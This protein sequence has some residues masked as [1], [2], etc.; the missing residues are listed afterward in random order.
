MAVADKQ[1]DSIRKDYLKIYGPAVLMTLLA[2]VLAYQFVDPA[3]PDRI[4]MVTGREG[5]AYYSFA[6]RYAEILAR[7]RVT[8]EIRSTAGSV[9]NIKLLESQTEEVDLAFVQSGLEASAESGELVSLGSVYFEPLWVFVRREVEATSLADLHH[10]RMAVGEEGSGTRAVA[11]LLLKD[12]GIDVTRS[13]VLPMASGV[14]ARALVAGAIDA[15]F[16]VASPESAVVRELIRND[17]VV[18]MNFERAEAYTRRHRFLSAVDLPKGVLDFRLNIPPDDVTLLA[19]TANL[20]VSEDFHPAL[21]DL[22]LQV[23]EE[24]H[25]QGSLFADAGDFPCAEFL[26]FPLSKEAERF[27]RYGRPFLQKYMPFWAASLVDRLKVMLVP[28]IAMMF[29]LFKIMPPTYRWRVRSRI[30]RWYKQ[31]DAVALAAIDGT[32]EAESRELLT[33]LD[34][35]E[36]EVTKMSIPLSYHEEWYNLRLHINHVREQLQR[37][38]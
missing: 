7:Q 5:G 16:F 30:Y 22:V 13:S 21:V 1:T 33:K 23:A 26:A 29:P 15:A 8:L 20:V 36:N 31:L 11:L 9:E 27:Y 6:E 37:K 14:A 2:F 24:V 17:A 25:G 34:D 38:A 18:L 4:V 12:N 10:K 35:L 19:P 3:P 28:L 32:D